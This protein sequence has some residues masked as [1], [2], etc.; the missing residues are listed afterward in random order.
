MSTPTYLAAEARRHLALAKSL[1]DL[2]TD[3]A[4]RQAHWHL[5]QQE[6]ITAQLAALKA[7]GNTIPDDAPGWLSIDGGAGTP[8]V[9]KDHVLAPETKVA[10]VLGT[11]RY[12]DDACLNALGW[13][14]KSMCVPTDGR[15]VTKA[16][17]HVGSSKDMLSSGGAG[18]LVPD[19]LANY[20]IDLARA[21]TVV[22]QLG[23]RTV[24]MTSETLRVPR[25]TGDVTA[26]WYAEGATLTGTDATLDAV[27]LTA[28]R[29][30]AGPT[31]VSMELIEDS[32]PIAVATVVADSIAAAVALEIDRVA[33]RGTGTPPQ[34]LGVKNASGV[35]SYSMGTPNGGAAD[36]S[37]LIAMQSLLAQANHTGNGFVLHP[38][39][40]HALADTKDSTGQFVTPPAV[41]STVPLG[42][43]SALPVNLTE[44]TS[45]TCTELYAGDWRQL[46]IGV[47]TELALTSLLELYRAEGKV[48]IVGR[49]RVDVAVEHGN[50]FVYSGDTTN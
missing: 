49:A 17:Q 8:V 7:G 23:A 16:L 35:Q 41:V 33:L 10:D 30:E 9:R 28:R 22:S 44:G 29:I 25:L 19:P 34:P 1:K 40:A 15:E 43:T 13:I 50:A 48:G 36:Y 3:E 14:V 24:P 4:V 2:G 26:S 46:L 20:L 42:M 21:K 5:Q 39:T 32:D 12:S 11:A 31:K 38:R 45:S 27:V 18:N 6:T 37:D 47:R